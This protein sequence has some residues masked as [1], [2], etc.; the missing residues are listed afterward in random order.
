MS[1]YK[2]AASYLFG[3]AETQ[4]AHWDTASRALSQSDA[5]SEE[6]EILR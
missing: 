3:R 5:S 6:M 4:N 2:D 1:R